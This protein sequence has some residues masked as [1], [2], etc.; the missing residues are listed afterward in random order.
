MKRLVSLIC[1]IAMIVSLSACNKT[2][3][4]EPATGTAVPS[5]TTENGTT[6][7]EP[8]TEPSA[9]RKTLTMDLISYAENDPTDK[10]FEEALAEVTGYDI[11]INWIPTIGYADK[12][13]TLIAADSLSQMTILNGGL[14]SGNAFRTGT[15]TGMFW[16]ID[17]YMDQ[18]KNLSVMSENAYKNTRIEG[19]LYGIPRERALV[20]QGFIYRK[21]WAEEEGFSRPESIDGIINMIEVFANRDGVKYGLTSGY[22]QDDYLPEGLLYTAIYMGAPNEWGFDA[23]GKLTHMFTT[24]EYFEAVKV[25]NYFYTSGLLNQNYLEINQDDGKTNAM[26]NEETGF[27]FHYADGVG[28]AYPELYTKNPDAELWFG[29]GSKGRDNV[30][31]AVATSGY[32]GIIV[33]SK[34]AN[35]DEADLLDCMSWINATATVEAQDLFAWGV[36]GYSYTLNENGKGIRSEEQEA[37][38]GQKIGYYGQANPF[39]VSLISSIDD[40]SLT[41]LHIAARDEK[42]DYYDVAVGNEAS[43]L[44]SSTWLEIG[45]IELTPI[46]SDTVNMYIQGN[47]GEAEYWAGVQ[48]WLDSGGQDVIDEYNEAYLATK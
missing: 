37:V 43:A 28:G 27:V 6:V 46:M 38:Y 24:E 15:N 29:Y 32:N 41:D 17:D 25:W 31:R 19:K 36:E 22:Q 40:E 10:V 20:R 48:E 18:F 9:E 5:G 3:T 34:T 12:I 16:Q 7:T 35:P 14:F 8:M 39:S 2:E 13:N 26:V 1:S 47:I 23:D 30:E 42:F 21:D 44:T 33:F 4:G 45:A 11:N